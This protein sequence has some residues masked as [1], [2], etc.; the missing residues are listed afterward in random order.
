MLAG[1]FFYCL[2]Y[3]DEISQ[4]YVFLAEQI[5]K[6]EAFSGN[7]IFYFIHPILARGKI[8]KKKHVVD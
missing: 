2:E 6:S 8:Q 5:Q 4:T 7:G 1:E 3:Q